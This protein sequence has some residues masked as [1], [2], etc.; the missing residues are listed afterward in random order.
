MVETD[1]AVW[2]MCAT[3]TIPFRSRS[4]NRRQWYSVASFWLGKSPSQIEW[5]RSTWGGLPQVWHQNNNGAAAGRQ[6]IGIDH[7]GCRKRGF[8]CHSLGLFFWES[9]V[10]VV[11]LGVIWNR[12]DPSG[13]EEHE[14]VKFVHL[15]RIFCRNSADFYFPKK[16]LWKTTFFENF[17][18][19]SH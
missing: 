9:N 11:L 7:Y 12:D 19:K 17:L 14:K 8:C 5:I 15:S 4:T 10:L 6:H 16:L 2:H 18:K 1:W 3:A 13:R